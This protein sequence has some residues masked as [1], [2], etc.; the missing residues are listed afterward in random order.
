MSVSVIIPAY[1][2]QAT[3]KRCIN[4]VIQQT[5]DEHIEII[6]V[7]DG[8]S[9]GTAEIVEHLMGMWPTK[10]RCIKLFS[11]ENQGV[12]IARNKGI[13]LSSGDFIAFLD[14]DDYWHPQKLEI[15]LPHM[16]SNNISVMGHSYIL[17]DNSSHDFLE[18]PL[19][20]HLKV[21]SFREQLLKNFAVTPSIVVCRDS[22]LLFDPNLKYA[23]DHEMLARL[24]L[25][26]QL[27]YLELPLVILDRPPLSVGGA[28]GNRLQMRLGEMKMYLS[29]ARYSKKVMFG[30]PFLIL[31][32]CLKHI[33]REVLILK[34]STLFNFNGE[35]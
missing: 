16:E 31:F 22:C 24:A 30:L 18:E 21:I 17:M 15:V 13:E 7:N 9:D 34:N 8:S 35:K 23:E 3:L 4:S 14:A 5:L 32:S 2:A 12:S 28:S 26:C 20:N 19:V 6:V 25:N 1:N 29:L 11:Q 27:T 10:G 33:R